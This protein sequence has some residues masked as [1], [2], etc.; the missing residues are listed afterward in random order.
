MLVLS[1]KN[2]QA[3]VVGGADGFENSLKVTV[4][5]VSGRSVRLGFETNREVAVHREEVWLRIVAGRAREPPVGFAGPTESSG[6]DGSARML[7]G[8]GKGR[9]PLPSEERA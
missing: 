5:D 9:S 1:R 4:L 8:T 3:V 2:N 6:A 7:S